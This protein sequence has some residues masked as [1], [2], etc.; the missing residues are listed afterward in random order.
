MA[1]IKSFNDYKEEHIKGDEKWMNIKKIVL[2]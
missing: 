2:S 1:D